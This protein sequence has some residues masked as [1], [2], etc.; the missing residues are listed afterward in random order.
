MS[1]RFLTRE[2]FKGFTTGMYDEVPHDVSPA[3]RLV[4][5]SV[6]SAGNTSKKE[7]G[8]WEQTRVGC[9]ELLCKPHPTIL[10]AWLSSRKQEINF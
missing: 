10:P 6:E 7:A 4:R 2:E 1:Y 8:V 9:G 5:Y 3:G